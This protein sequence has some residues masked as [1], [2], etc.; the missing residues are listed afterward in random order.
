MAGKQ[1]VSAAP[2]GEGIQWSDLK[3]KL[4]VVEPLDIEHMV[5]QFSKGVEQECVRANVYAVLSKDGSK[6]ESFEDT[7][8]FPKVLI[9]QTKRQIGSYVVGKLGQ[10]EAK[11]GQDAPW[12]MEEA[13]DA[14]LKAANAFLTSRSVTS[15]G[16]GGDDFADEDGDESF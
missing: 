15:A 7:L 9:S 8:I 2:G 14:Q 1:I 5:T 16:D 4:L 10:G 6:S 11:S 12:K 3:G 13:N